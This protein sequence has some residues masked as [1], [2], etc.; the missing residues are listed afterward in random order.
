MT[1]LERNILNSIIGGT[2]LAAVV[3][4]TTVNAADIPSA[5]PVE[6]GVVSDVAVGTTGR[7]NT[8]L[9]TPN[10]W[11]Y[12]A[13]QRLVKHG[14]V[15]DTKGYVFDGTTSYTKD[16]LMPLINEIVEK[17]EQMNDNDREFALRLYQENTRDIMNYRIERD[18][19]ETLEKRR[20]ADEKRAQKNKD[21][22]KPTAAQQEALDQA[23]DD[24]NNPKEEK[25][26]TDEQIKEKM[27]HFK[28][29]D[30][31]VKVGGDVRIR[32]GKTSGGKS[33]TDSRVRTELAFTL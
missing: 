23:T 9:I 25:A 15:T 12:T 33:T 3:G 1:R 20:K 21:K 14:A 8:N 24:I 5:I 6:A 2:L 32:Y 27:K 29:D 13:I 31:R 30:S 7:G 17:R 16:Q 19:Q 11:T 22:A 18:R 4:L 28:I 10:D 26:L